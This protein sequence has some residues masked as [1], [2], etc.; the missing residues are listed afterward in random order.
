MRIESL[1]NIKRRDVNIALLFANSTINSY[2][3]QLSYR[4]K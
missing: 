1:I 4:Y 3:T 2:L